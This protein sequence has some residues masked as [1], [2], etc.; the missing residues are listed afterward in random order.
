MSKINHSKLVS[1]SCISQSKTRRGH[2]FVCVLTYEGLHNFVNI[3]VSHMKLVNFVAP[4]LGF[5][6]IVNII[7]YHLYSYPYTVKD[8]LRFWTPET[9]KWCLNRCVDFA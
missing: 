3:R 6:Y 5:T 9:R 2:L 4:S 8:E 7:K 1:S